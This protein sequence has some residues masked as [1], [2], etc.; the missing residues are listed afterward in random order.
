MAPLLLHLI[1]HPASSSARQLARTLHRGFNNDSALPHL[2]VPT[3]IVP[4]DGSLLPPA[5]YDLD[6]AERSVVIVLADDQLAIERDVP[7]GRASWPEFVV[8]LR[9]RCE[10]GNHRF[11]PVQLSA[12]AWPLH[13]DLR[14]IN[15]IRAFDGAEEERAAALEHRIVVETCRFLLK[16]TRGVQAPVKLFLSHAKLDSAAGPFRE[17]VAHLD[18]TQ[19]VE[20]WIDSGKIEPGGDF[21]AAIEAGVRDTAVLAVVTQHYSSRPWCRREILFA[22]KYG[23]PLVVLDAL[24][25]VDVRSFPYLGNA[26]I[27]SW[28]PGGADK[29]IRLLMKEQ[30]RHLHS[31]LLMQRSRS[32]TDVVLPVAPELSTIASLPPRSSVLYPDPPLGDEE[33]EVLQAISHSIE[34]PLQRV[35]RQ[36]TLARRKIALSIS[37]PDTLAGAGMLLEHLDA[38]L[39]EISR[40]LLCQG[41]VLMYGG[42]LGSA[43]YTV[44]LFDLVLQHQALSGL[45]APERIV[46]YV[47]WP[48]P[49]TDKQRADYRWQTKF[50]RTPRPPNVEA[51]EPAT[52]VA[53]PAYFPADTAARRFAWARGMTLMREQQTGDLDARVV[54][55]GKVGPTL[56]ATPEGGTKESWYS[57]RIPGVVEEAILTLTAGKPLYL[58]GAFGG[59]AALTIE[60]LEGRVPSAFTWDYQ[61]RAPHAAGMRDIYVQQGL[62]WIDY[63]QLARTCADI[64]VAG[65]SKT[66]RLT[67]EENRELFRTRDVPRIVELLLAGMTRG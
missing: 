56:T 63:P 61:Q 36:R 40:H 46:N 57:G 52:F 14:A 45:P 11:L 32:S 5:A 15:F 58:C 30:F 12:N 4:E 13:E 47:G 21:T 51:L 24:D 53:E 2:A 7:A 18:A 48:L 39:L 28:S 49:L 67:A 64:G 55:G 10:A 54:L 19:S 44:K 43:G 6:E 29:A 22:K 50:V 60:L 1:F 17:L 20:A 66:N 9:R 42:H 23:R 26:P 31:S 37:E 62:E 25:G 65:L 59:A 41:A 8:E 16:K 35:A 27:I 38:A 33:T 3:K 34:T